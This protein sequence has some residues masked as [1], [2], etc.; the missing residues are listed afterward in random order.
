MSKYCFKQKNNKQ[1]PKHKQKWTPKTRGINRLISFLAMWTP[2][3]GSGGGCGT[4]V[5]HLVGAPERLLGFR[6]WS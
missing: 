2:M 1:T 3:C 6:P 4:P 5:A